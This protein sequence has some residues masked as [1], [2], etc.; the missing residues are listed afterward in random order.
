MPRLILLVTLLITLPFATNSFAQTRLS[1]E[2]A[3]ARQQ[4][5]II[6]RQGGLEWTGDWRN[7]GRGQLSC[8][9]AEASPSGG[10]R[11]CPHVFRPVCAIYRGN[12]RTFSNE[13]VAV[14]EGYDVLHAGECRSPDFGQDRGD[15]VFN[16]REPFQACPNVYRPVCGVYAGELRTFGNACE[17][18]TAGYGIAYEAPCGTRSVSQRQSRPQFPPITVPTPPLPR[19]QI[20]TEPR[21]A[22]NGNSAD[23]IAVIE[24]I[25]RQE[26]RLNVLKDQQRETEKRLLLLK[27]RKSALEKSLQERPLQPLTPNINGDAQSGPAVVP[28]ESPVPVTKP[29]SELSPEAGIGTESEADGEIGDTIGSEEQDAPSSSPASSPASSGSNG[30]RVI[31]PS[32]VQASQAACEGIPASQVCGG[33]NGLYQRFKNACFARE[34]GYA[35]SDMANCGG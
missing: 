16:R 32:P 24:E 7:L 31:L 4:C 13:C 33:R 9:C 8:D 11:A 3:M 27:E 25:K 10:I 22:A 15:N 34:A 18:Q 5:P 12:S 21:N 19:P 14:L 6:C 28:F 23:L 26:T 20:S 1:G 35:L 2:D 17:A 30:P 29:E